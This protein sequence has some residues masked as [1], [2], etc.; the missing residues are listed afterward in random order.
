MRLVTYNP[1]KETPTPRTGARGFTATT[2]SVFLDPNT[3]TPISDELLKEL[4]IDPTFQALKEAGALTITDTSPPPEAVKSQP[5]DRVFDL[6]VPETEMA[7]PA[8]MKKPK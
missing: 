8:D 2:G 1:K 6:P 3:P 4:E 7:A 5:Q